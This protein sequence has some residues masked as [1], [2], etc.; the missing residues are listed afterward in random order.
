MIVMLY[1]GNVSLTRRPTVNDM[2]DDAQRQILA[3]VACLVKEN[4]FKNLEAIITLL[5]TYMNIVYFTQYIL[6]L[7]QI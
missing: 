5:N 1:S 3:F 4:I 7:T 6:V 2:N